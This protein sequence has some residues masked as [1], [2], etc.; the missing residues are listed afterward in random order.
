[1]DYWAETMQDDVYLIVQR[2]LARGRQAPAHRRGQGQKKT[3]EKPDFT[4]G[5][6]KFKS[7]LIPGPRC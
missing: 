2:R 3:K 7:D 1:M 4:V 6:Q 5:K